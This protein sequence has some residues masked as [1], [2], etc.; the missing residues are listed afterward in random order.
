MVMW[1][2]I[3]LALKTYLWG[4]PISLIIVMLIKAFYPISENEVFIFPY[5]YL[6]TSLLVIAVV[7]ILT[8][9]YSTKKIGKQNIIETIREDSI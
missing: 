3:Y 7:I 5:D 1:E 2:G 8:I 4:I 9:G 6:L